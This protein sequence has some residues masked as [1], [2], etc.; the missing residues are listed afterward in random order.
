MYTLIVMVIIL[1]PW[2]L[3]GTVLI[4]WLIQRARRERAVRQAPAVVRRTA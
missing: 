1:F 4:G 3:V 2:S